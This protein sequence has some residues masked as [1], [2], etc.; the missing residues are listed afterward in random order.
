MVKPVVISKKWS[1]INSSDDLF[2]KKI[3][4]NKNK[5]D[6]NIKNAYWTHHHSLSM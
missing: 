3:N 5:I 1:Q 2:D 6:P 4:K